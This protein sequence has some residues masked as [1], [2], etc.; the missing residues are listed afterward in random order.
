MNTY[1][2]FYYRLIQKSNEIFMRP[3]WLQEMVRLFRN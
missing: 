1:S 3:P 2:I